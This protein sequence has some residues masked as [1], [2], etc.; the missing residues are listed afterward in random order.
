MNTQFQ[1]LIRYFTSKKSLYWVVLF[2]VVFSISA[3]QAKGQVT[4]TSEDETIIINN[5][6]N[7]EPEPAP[8]SVQS[9]EEEHQQQH[10]HQQQQQQHYQEPQSAPESVGN[11]EVKPIEKAPTPKETPKK[12][13]TKKEKIIFVINPYTDV[14]NDFIF[15]TNKILLNKELTNEEREYLKELKFELS[16][17]KKEIEKYLE[18]LWEKKNDT[19]VKCDECEIL[20]KS[21]NDLCTNLDKLSSR[22]LNSLKK[23]S[24]N[25]VTSWKTEFRKYVLEPTV[26]KDSLALSEIC[27]E[28]DKRA[29]SS[30]LG[31]LGINEV[32]EKLSEVERNYHRIITESERFISQ[33]LKEYNDENDKAVIED[34]VNEIPACYKEIYFYRDSLANIKIPYLLLSL[35][36]V[37]VL[38]LLIGA[39]FL[40]RGKHIDKK[41]KI[42]KA[43]NKTILIEEDDVVE[44]ISYIVNLSDVKDKAGEEYY[45]VKMSQIHEDT[46]IQSIYFSRKA[47]FEIYKF[48]SDFLKYNDKINETG[49]FLVGRWDYASSPY[50]QLY[51]ISIESFVEPG[52]DAIYGEFSLNFGA[53][54]GITLN[55]SIENLC[56]KTGKEYVHTAWMHSHPGLGLFLSGQDLNVQSQL[57]HSQHRGRMLA[58]VLDSN[59]PDF[60]MAFFAPRKNG[61]MNNDKDLKRTLSL[62]EM[63]QWAKSSPKNIAQIKEKQKLQFDRQNFYDV[64][65]HPNNN[66]NKALFHGSVIIDMD[67]AI[68]PD[69]K[70]LRGYFFGENQDNEI[71]LNSFV[72]STEKFDEL[73]LSNTE[74]ADKKPVACFIVENNLE[75]L[76]QHSSLF[77][78]F[79]LYVVYCLDDEK[80]F[81]LTKDDIQNSMESNENITSVSIMKMKQW[82][83]RVR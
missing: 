65:L 15:K 25:V 38:L 18:N 61:S 11:S 42:E 57:A 31:W 40:I 17:L 55:Y 35:A 59:T 52:D 41:E 56:E 62:E 7:N 2:V 80:L 79:D 19:K 63:Y 60:R 34:L 45:E 51:D 14:V 77:T 81:L 47:I 82:T 46:T 22:I 44:T 39:F 70:G 48:F 49:G 43:A 12:T 5:H 16:N 36:G 37:V 66:I 69:N 8:V 74:N 72:E 76:A 10:H 32:K 4:T 23:V 26:E 54:I 6:N 21:S 28:I 30:L 20:I 75:S 50:Q 67:M 13:E 9:N 78:L 64:P 1:T 27:K 29:Q 53:K 68:M 73:N 3:Q 71:I 33:K 83:R 58:I 24:D